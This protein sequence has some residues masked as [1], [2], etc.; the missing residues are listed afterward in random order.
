MNLF[1]P[2]FCNGPKAALPNTKPLTENPVTVTWSVFV[3]TA[4]VKGM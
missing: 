2:L 1:Y 4:M 3:I